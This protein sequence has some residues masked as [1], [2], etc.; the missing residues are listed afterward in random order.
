MRA[1]GSAPESV[2]GD[3]CGE[4]RRVEEERAQVDQPGIDDGQ[5]VLQMETHDPWDQ[6]EPEAPRQGDPDQDCRRDATIAVKGQLASKATE[7][8]DATS[9]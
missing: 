8:P 7:S 9:R 5:A 4:E 2:N 6:A 1:G 3:E